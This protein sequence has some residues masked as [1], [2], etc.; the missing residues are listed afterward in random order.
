MNMALENVMR[1]DNGNIVSGGGAGGSSV[2]IDWEDWCE[3]TPEEQETGDWTIINCPWA[4]GNVSI[5]LMTKLWENPNPTASFAAQTVALSGM[6]YGLY[7]L[8]FKISDTWD[9]SYIIDSKTTSTN[10]VETL[11]SAMTTLYNR[12]FRIVSNGISFDN[13][14]VGATTNNSYVIPYRIYGI[15]LT[16]T[17]KINAIAMDVSTSADKCMLSDGVTSVEDKFGAQTIGTPVDISGYLENN[18]YTFPSDGYVELKATSSGAYVVVNINGM[19]SIARSAYSDYVI[20]YVRK[21]M[22]FYKTLSYTG[23]HFCNFYPLS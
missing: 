15:K 12:G 23:T 21:G 9:V 5:D 18:K 1:V 17:V 7:F 19:T 16:A 11:N 10:W 8:V 22:V 2:E 3:L 6:D 13:A 4:D 20:I 14:R